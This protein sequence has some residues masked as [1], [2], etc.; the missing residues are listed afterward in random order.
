MSGFNTLWLP[1]T[2]H[3]GIAT[4]MIVERE[5]AKQGIS[6]FD[7]GREKFVEKSVGVEGVVRP[8]DHRPAQAPRRVGR[9]DAPPLHAR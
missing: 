8:P 9:L 4:Q 6:R 5:L 2:D 1:G 3:A 7:L